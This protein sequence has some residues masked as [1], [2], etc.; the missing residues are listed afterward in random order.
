[1][2]KSS[3][4]VQAAG[5]TSRNGETQVGFRRV[6][7]GN[8]GERVGQ[9]AVGGWVGEMFVGGGGDL[10]LTLSGYLTN[11]RRA[12]DTNKEIREIE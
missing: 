9:E 3:N 12:D 1:M 7:S 11:R 8:V 5:D 6:G 4:G 2:R 10:T